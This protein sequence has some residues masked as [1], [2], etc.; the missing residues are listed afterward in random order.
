MAGRR[1]A[2]VL[3]V[4]IP[5]DAEGRTEGSAEDRTVEEAEADSILEE[6]RSEQPRHPLEIVYRVDDDTGE[7]GWAGKFAAS[8]VTPEFLAKR[9]GPGKYKCYLR[10][11]DKKGKM[12]FGGSRTVSVIADLR[13]AVMN[14]APPLRDNGSGDFSRDL[15]LSMMKQ[16]QE[17]SQNMVSMMATMMTA[18]TTAFG[19]LKPTTDPMMMAVIQGMMQRKDPTEIATGL[20]AAMKE[21]GGAGNPISQLREL[22]EIKEL[23]GG[24]DG[25]AD[26]ESAMIMKGMDTLREAIHVAGGRAF[27]PAPVAPTPPPV[28]PRALPAGPSADAAPPQPS[29]P[30][31]VID[32]N[33]R[34]WKRGVLQN[35]PMFLQA[36]AFMPPHAAAETAMEQMRVAG[37]WPD[38]V[39]DVRSDYPVLDV[40]AL[41]D[42]FGQAFVERSM[43]DLQMARQS[44]DVQDWAREVLYTLAE[45]AVEPVEKE[46]GT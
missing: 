3:Q 43:T 27:Q 15:L 9:L 41:P 39:E 20:M 38:V 30:P 42:E 35:L 11:P 45:L 46:E 16:G 7:E 36:A 5:E 24:G 2:R 10:K 6:A 18:M 12:G 31:M 1:G 34:A 44:G 32:P 33:L 21:S 23:L 4:E 25:N 19:S 17:N 22:L 26:P 13:P 8:A 40:D 37:V 28:V 29:E 14:G